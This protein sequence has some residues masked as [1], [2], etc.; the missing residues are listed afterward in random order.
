[1]KYA[2]GLAAAFVAGCLFSFALIAAAAAIVNRL[3]GRPSG[4]RP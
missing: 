4:G 1:V 3:L 2:W